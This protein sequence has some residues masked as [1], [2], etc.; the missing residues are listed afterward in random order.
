MSRF[1]HRLLWKPG[2]I[3][4]GG[5]A[6]AA[7]WLIRGRQ[8]WDLAIIIEVTIVIAAVAAYIQGGRKTGEGT[9]AASQRDE[10]QHLVNQ[11]SRALAGIVALVASFLGVTVGVAVNGTWWWP[12]LAIFAITGF[13]YLYG[14]STFG[15]GE[16]GPAED[17]DE[18]GGGAQRPAGDAAGPAGDAAGPAGGDANS[19]Y[20][21]RSPVSS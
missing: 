21:A 9:L 2:I 19:G 20:Q 3:F 7:A 11:R 18:P 13:A 16:E 1:I 10:R 6:F 8:S 4:A 5:T 14:L 17:E 15:V 12:C